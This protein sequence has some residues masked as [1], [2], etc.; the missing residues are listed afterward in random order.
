MLKTSAS[1][2]QG[3]V[4]FYSF[5]KHNTVINRNKPLSCLIFFHLI[6]ISLSQTCSLL[7]WQCF[8]CVFDCQAHCLTRS[9]T[10]TNSLRFL[11]IT[12]GLWETFKRNMSLNSCGMGVLLHLLFVLRNHCDGN[13]THFME[14]YYGKR[15]HLENMLHKLIVNRSELL[16]K[17]YGFIIMIETINC[18]FVL[19]EDC[20]IN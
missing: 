11:Q 17:F 13:V 3:K 8:V 12:G 19:L 18:M 20:C 1:S 16:L 7:S 4:I 6:S 5:K 15:F 10:S 14:L 2:A 9:V